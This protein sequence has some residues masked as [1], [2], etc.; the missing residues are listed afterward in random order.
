MNSWH[1][2]WPGFEASGS[3]VLPLPASEFGGL[4]ETLHVGELVLARK[5]EFHVTLLLHALG[6]RLQRAVAAD[7]R[8][9]AQ[10]PELFAA[11]DW[12]WQRRGERWL[13]RDH[14]AH[15]VIEIIEM[16]ALH[17]FRQE[18][19]KRLG[20]TLPPTPAHITLYLANTSRGIGLSSQTEFE[21]L[22]LHRLSS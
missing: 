17:A 13:L 21:A 2:R 18:I 11:L 8:L 14:G 1:P 5:R 4:P 15:T 22:R 3:L 20:E 9:V 6:V 10:L 19:G 12:T 7:P 16:P